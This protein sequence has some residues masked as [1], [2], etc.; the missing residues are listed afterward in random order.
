MANLASK[1]NEWKI[2]DCI[3]IYH[4]P[5]QY[6]IWVRSRRWGCLVTWFCYQMIAKPGNR[7]SPPPWPDPYHSQWWFLLLIGWKLWGI[8]AYPSAR[9]IQDFVL[10][11]DVTMVTLDDVTMVTFDDVTMVT[12]DG[13]LRCC[14]AHSDSRDHSVYASGQWGMV[15]H[16][17][18]SL[19]WAGRMQRI[20]PR[21]GIRTQCRVSSWFWPGSASC[22]IE[23]L[24]IDKL[25]HWGWDKMAAIFQ[26]TFSNAFSSMKIYEFRLKLHWSL[27][28]R[29]QLTIFHHWFR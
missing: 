17:N 11:D 10:F 4:H 22:G 12:F 24:Q 16:C 25:T 26:T 19:P 20:S 13:F 29:V 2:V 3:Y 14:H 21:I 7:T 1:G 15:L 27:F 9:H 5:I 6:S 28:L 8:D 23:L 18:A